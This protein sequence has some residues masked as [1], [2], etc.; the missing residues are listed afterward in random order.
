MDADGRNQSSTSSL[1]RSK[2]LATRRNHAV[3]PLPR[4]VSTHELKPPARVSDVDGEDATTQGEGV[5]ESHIPGKYVA[6]DCEMVGVGP[7]PDNDSQ[8]ARVSLVNWHGKQVYDSYVQPIL[9]VSDYRTQVSGIRP[10]HLRP[11]N[12]AR[13]FKEVQA[14]VAA[15]LAG[16]TLVGHYMKKDFFVLGLKHPPRE[17]RDTS[18]LQ[19]Y[20]EICKGGPKLKDLAHKVL[21]LDIQGGEHDSVEDARAAMMLYK[22]AKE[23]MDAEVDKRFGRPIAQQANKSAGNRKK[24]RRK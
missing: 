2:S 12:G 24:G 16:R 17:T 11:E 18:T 22:A 20:R 3:K 7:F 8:L 15:F 1:K 21:G 23:E 13:P 4:P 6:L 5:S 10:H 14:D 19:R 9:P